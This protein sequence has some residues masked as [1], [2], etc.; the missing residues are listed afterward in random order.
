MQRTTRVH[1]IAPYK[2]IYLLQGTTTIPYVHIDKLDRYNIYAV[3]YI[4]VIENHRQYKLWRIRKPIQWLYLYDSRTQIHTH[5]QHV[6]TSRISFFFFFVFIFIYNTKESLYLRQHISTT[7][8]GMMMM[9]WTRTTK[10]TT[11]TN[12]KK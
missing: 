11:E 4:H 3:F 10:N 8:I 9:I 5:T 12:E 2:P 1:V 7:F 6:F